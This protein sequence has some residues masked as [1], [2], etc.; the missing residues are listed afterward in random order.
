MYMPRI[1]LIAYRLNLTGLCPLVFPRIFTLE[2]LI[3]KM[4][5][6]VIIPDS[7]IHDEKII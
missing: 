2:Q 5:E 7:S 6:R 1:M 3:T 4:R